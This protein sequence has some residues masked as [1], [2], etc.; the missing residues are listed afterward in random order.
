MSIWLEDIFED[1]QLVEKIKRGLPYLFQL[2]K[3]ES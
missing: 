3:S 1:K 2:A